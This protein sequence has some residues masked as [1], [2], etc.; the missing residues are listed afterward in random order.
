[1]VQDHGGQISCHNRPQ[2]GAVFVLRFPMAHE[3]AQVIA[4]AA[5]VS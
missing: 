2:G 3:R 1:V 5:Q 4:K